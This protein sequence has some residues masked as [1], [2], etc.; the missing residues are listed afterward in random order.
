LS[1]A[2]QVRMA[3]NVLPQVAFVTV[4]VIWMVILVPSQMSVAVGSVNVHGVPHSIVKFVEHAISGGVVS[5][6][7]TAWLQLATLPQSSIV[8]QVRVAMKALPQ[9]ILNLVLTMLMAG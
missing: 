3:T 6:T 7:V 2:L 5:T 8:L 4:L 1:V 9:V